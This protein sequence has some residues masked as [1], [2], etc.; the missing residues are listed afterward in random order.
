MEDYSGLIISL[1]ILPGYGR[2]PSPRRPLSPSNTRASPLNSTRHQHGVLLHHNKEMQAL[3]LLRRASAPTAL[4][5]GQHVRTLSVAITERC[6][7]VR[8][9]SRA[10]PPR[11]FALTLLPCTLVSGSPP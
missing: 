4:L 10:P 1:Q 6:A 9:F 7:Q 3:H 5:F 8:A 11:P 2:V